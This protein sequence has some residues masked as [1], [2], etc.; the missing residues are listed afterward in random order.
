MAGEPRQTDLAALL[1]NETTFLAARRSYQPH[2]CPRLAAGTGTTRPL[3]GFDLEVMK[4]TR[5]QLPFVSKNKLVEIVPDSQSHPEPPRRLGI[6]LS[7]GRPR[8]ATTSLPACSTRPSGL[9]PTAG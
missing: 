7:G 5:E 2:L 9:T 1:G 6:V 4:A 8:G 3:P